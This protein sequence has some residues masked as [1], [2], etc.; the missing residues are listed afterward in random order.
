MHSYT[1]IALGDKTICTYLQIINYHVVTDM[2]IYIYIYF[3]LLSLIIIFWVLFSVSLLLLFGN[4]ST[5]T[6]CLFI[7]TDVYIS[8]TSCVQM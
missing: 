3:F 2:I 8:C 5:L 4:T 1:L 6:L 7:S